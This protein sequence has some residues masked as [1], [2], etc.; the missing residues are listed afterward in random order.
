[1]NIFKCKCANIMLI[2][3]HSDTRKYNTM[4]IAI[5]FSVLHEYINITDYSDF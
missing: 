3:R 4:L 1:M 5:S 2:G